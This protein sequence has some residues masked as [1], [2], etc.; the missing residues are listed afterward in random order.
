MRSDGVTENRLTVGQPRI[1]EKQHSRSDHQTRTRTAQTQYQRSNP[2]SYLGNSSGALNF[3]GLYTLSL[4]FVI[5]YFITKLLHIQ[6]RQQYTRFKLTMDVSTLR[7]KLWIPQ[8]SH[9]NDD[10]SSLDD[11]PNVLSE[12][13][14]VK[15][16]ETPSLGIFTIHLNPT[17]KQKNKLL[18]LLK[19]SNMAFNWCK[20]LVEEKELSVKSD[21]SQI[22]HIIVCKKNERKDMIPP[23]VNHSLLAGTSQTRN[24]G[25]R[26]FVSSFKAN[27]KLHKGDCSKFVIQNKPLEEISS[28][29]FSVQK[30]FVNHLSSRD[31]CDPSVDRKML[32]KIIP[33]YFGSTKE[34]LER[35]FRF[36]KARSVAR[37]P[38]IDHDVT[39]SLRQNGKWMLNIPCKR[40]YTR[41]ANLEQNPKLPVVALDPGVRVFQ[42]AYDPFLCKVIEFGKKEDLDRL[43]ELKSKA[44]EATALANSFERDTQVYRDSQRHALKKWYKFKKARKAFHDDIH[45]HLVFKYHN[46]VIGNFSGKKCSLKSRRRLPSHTRRDIYTWGNYDFKQKLKDRC[47]GSSTRFIE[48]CERNT[49]KTCGWCGKQNNS[50]GCNK[51]FTCSNCGLSIDRD[52]NAARNILI[53][54]ITEN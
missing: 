7:K 47:E 46:V 31:K 29:S 18:T 8:S 33:N 11:I 13:Y 21:L 40:R 52:Y 54:N 30:L 37:M 12:K 36:A 6:Q 41:V 35:Y 1:A 50:L 23:F 15:T 14:Q 10:F 5:E 43:N 27:M 39:I 2:L 53:K 51:T 9:Q 26:S 19:V 38:P 25:F 16:P 24:T 17:K 3:S 44:E 45:S 20:W 32:I 22:Q 34:P 4:S 48:Q 49:S 42:T 28:G